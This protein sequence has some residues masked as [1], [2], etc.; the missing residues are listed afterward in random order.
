VKE[1]LSSRLLFPATERAFTYRRYDAWLAGLV[2]ERVLPL[3]ELAAAEAPVLGLR[4]DVDSRLDSAVQLARLE[5]R[6]GIRSTYFILHT[7]PYYRRDAEF[8]RTLL[9]LQ[10]DL[11]HEV[12][13]HNDLV[14]LERVRGVDVRSYLARE[15]EWLRAGGIDVRGAAAHGSPWCYRLGFHNNYVF[16][17]WDEPQEGFPSL[18]VSDKLDPAEFGLEYEAYHLPYDEYFS[19][20]SFGPSGRRHPDELPP[21]ELA[22]GR[23]VA[24]VHP[25][26]WDA[27]VA[28]K[29]ARLGAKVVRRLL[30][31]PTQR[32]GV[33]PAPLR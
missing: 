11:G 33:R 23:A 2:P 31:V 9:V 6:R 30:R 21:Q 5:H 27:S 1:P 24:L 17:G 25:C 15:L 26:H 29:S 14:T 12:G 3:R 19:D 8:L 32:R 16:A 20:S 4:H 13:W 7:A 28:H 10:E 22:G 18:E